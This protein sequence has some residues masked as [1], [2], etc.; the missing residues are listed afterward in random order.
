M[1]GV[2][3]VSNLAAGCGTYCDFNPSGSDKE[4]YKVVQT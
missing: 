3:L 1:V 4:L 2:G